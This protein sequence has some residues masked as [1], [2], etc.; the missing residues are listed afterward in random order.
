MRGRSQSI[1][2][3]VGAITHSKICYLLLTKEIQH[4]L[5][6]PS[7]LCL[8]LIFIKFPSFLGL[9]YS[10]NI[11]FYRELL[12]KI[13]PMKNGILLMNTNKVASKCFFQ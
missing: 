1:S 6:R 9:R 10:Q 8:R 3:I 7:K 4:F 11:H 13:K 12:F 5:V 2:K